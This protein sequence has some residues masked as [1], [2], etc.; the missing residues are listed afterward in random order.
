[1]LDGLIYWSKV[2]A[3]ASVFLFA[4]WNAG[5]Y[6]ELRPPTLKELRAELVPM[7]SDIAQL[8][9]SADGLRWRELNDR[10][11]QCGWGCLTFLE[12]QEFCKL[13]IAIGYRG[14]PECGI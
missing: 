8:F 1:M 3:A 6:T 9:A 2:F 14:I 13:S 4:G 11:L 10:R 12:Q 7:K 5:T